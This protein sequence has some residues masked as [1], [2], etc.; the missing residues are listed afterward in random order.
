MKTP[1]VKNQQHGSLKY[2]KSSP[3][4]TREEKVE[5]NKGHIEK[6]HGYRK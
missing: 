5:R 1:E 6:A 2:L 3:D 4:S